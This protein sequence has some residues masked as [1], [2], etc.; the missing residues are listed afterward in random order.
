M[1][2]HFLTG[3]LVLAFAGSAVAHPGHDHSH[4]T[5]PA[6]HAAFF[7]AVAAIIGAGVWRVRKS[8]H[9]KSDKQ[10]EE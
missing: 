10:G 3:L 7:I 6:V 5:S 4:W 1:L 9:T 2:K 8:R